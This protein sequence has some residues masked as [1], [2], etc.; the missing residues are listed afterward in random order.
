MSR[1]AKQASFSVDEVQKVT[2]EVI[3]TLVGGNTFQQSKVNQWSNSI[4][5]QTLA[6]LTKQSKAY[7][8]IGKNCYEM[9]CSAGS[10]FDCA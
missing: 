6:Q 2:K 8:Y 7:K 10:S 4:V 9:L 5:E 3:E 1:F